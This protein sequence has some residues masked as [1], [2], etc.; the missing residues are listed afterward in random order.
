MQ[1]PLAVD[2]DKTT[3]DEIWVNATLPEDVIKS[4]LM[5]YFD[6]MTYLQ[7]QKFIKKFPQK[8]IDEPTAIV[9]SAKFRKVKV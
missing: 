4:I 3:L 8:G 6:R 9:A 5:Q 7:R 2:F 1:I